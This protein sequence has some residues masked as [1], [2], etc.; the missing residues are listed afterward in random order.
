M[1]VAANDKVSSRTRNSFAEGMEK[2]AY[3]A[4]APSDD[5]IE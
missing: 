1:G 3:R 4:G 2:L 5:T